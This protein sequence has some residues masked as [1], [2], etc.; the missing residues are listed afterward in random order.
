[1]KRSEMIN[2]IYDIITDRELL[3]YEQ[4]YKMSEVI[5]KLVEEK[6]MLP[7]TIKNPELPKDMT[8]L[9][10]ADILAQGHEYISPKF[11]VNEWEEE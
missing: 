2:L 10:H 8:R 5:L 3:Y 6:G 1:M 7:P 4:F 11:E 9:E